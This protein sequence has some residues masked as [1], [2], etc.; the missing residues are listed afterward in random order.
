MLGFAYQPPQPDVVKFNRLILGIVMILGVLFQNI[1]L[2]YAYFGIN[3]LTLATTLQFSPTN[4]LFKGLKY[5]LKDLKCNISPAYECSY[6]MNQESERFELFSRLLVSL[7]A[8]GFYGDTPLVTWLIGMF[9]GIFMMISTFFG[10]CLSSLGY[11]GFKRFD[12]SSCD[13][14]IKSAA[15][16]TNCILARNGFK[17]YARCD[18]CSLSVQKCTGIQF[19]GFVFAISF[20]VASFMF[21]DD[22]VWIRLNIVLIVGVL[23]WLGYKVTINT[24]QL[25]SADVKNRDLNEQLKNY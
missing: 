17:P 3:L 23:F 10:V 6:F 12:K 20:L 8:I 16:N 19:N 7:I 1:E 22:P 11:I 25:A 15:T 13:N 2:L 24:D 18:S 4:W 5:F 9:M 14:S 21:L